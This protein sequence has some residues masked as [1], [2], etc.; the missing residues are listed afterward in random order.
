M[1]NLNFIQEKEPLHLS[2]SR[3]VC[4]ISGTIE[5]DSDTRIGSFL[6]HSH[7]LIHPIGS[8]YCHAIA[9]VFAPDGCIRW[10]NSY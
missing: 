3:A 5:L 2:D 6:T 4:I 1:N 9:D 10:S 7:G 8:I